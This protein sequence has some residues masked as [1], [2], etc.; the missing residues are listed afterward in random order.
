MQFLGLMHISLT[1]VLKE[2]W[3]D[4]AVMQKSPD[5]IRRLIKQCETVY[6][7]ANGLMESL[8]P[9]ESSTW[10]YRM[11]TQLKKIRWMFEKSR[12][13]V[14]LS[15]LGHSKVTL[16]L[17]QNLINTELALVRNKGPEVMSVAFCAFSKC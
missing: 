6:E 1:D 10:T 9:I 2:S 11:K 7:E 5:L 12:V 14:L 8:K 16:G 17:L 4:S 13:N 15:L 3:P